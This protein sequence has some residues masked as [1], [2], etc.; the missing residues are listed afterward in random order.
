MTRTASTTPL[1]LL[2]EAT[3]AE[4]GWETGWEPAGPHPAGRRVRRRSSETDQRELISG[5][6]TTFPFVV[7]SVY[8]Q[9][10]TLGSV[11]VG[12]NLTV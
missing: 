3:E 9:C 12:V 8:A 6:E 5:P 10:S 7:N 1:L 2:R 11:P 4:T